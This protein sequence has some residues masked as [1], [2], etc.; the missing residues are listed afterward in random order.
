MGNRNTESNGWNFSSAFHGVELLRN[1]V[2]A[3]SM[4]SNFHQHNEAAECKFDCFGWKVTLCNFWSYYTKYY[5][6]VKNALKLL[7][8]MSF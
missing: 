4:A 7:I 6:V 8:Y 5:T 3:P 1:L 2:R